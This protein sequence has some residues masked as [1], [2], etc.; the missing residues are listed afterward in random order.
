M[1][2]SALLLILLLITFPATAIAQEQQPPKP[3]AEELEKQKEEWTKNAYRLLDQVIDE[4]QS[5]RL[6]EN[7]VRMQ[8]YAADVLWDRDQGRARS[9]FMVAGDA[10]AELSRTNPE[11]T[12][13]RPGPNQVR[14]PSQLRQELVLT[15][16]RHDAPL[17]YQL[18][19]ATK[20][21]LPVQPVDPRQPRQQQFNADDLLEQSLLAAVAALDPKLAAQNADQMLEKG[22]FPYS[23]S[24]VISEL[25]RQDAEAATKLADKTVKRLQSANLLSNTEAAT[26]ALGLLNPGP[27]IPS[28]ADAAKPE[29]AKTSSQARGPVLDQSVYVDLLGSLI[30]SALKATPPTQQNQRGANNPRAARPGVARTVQVFRDDGTVITNQPSEAQTELMNARRLLSGL[31]RLLPQVD[32]NLPGRAQSVRQKL[33]EMGIA[34][35]NRG[36][37]AQIANAF[38]GDVTADALIQTAATAPTQIQPRL[39]QQAAFKALEEGNVDRARQIATDHLS[40]QRLRDSVMQRID[41]RE[42]A[43]KAEG[44]RLEQVRQSLSRLQSDN[45]RIDLLLQLANDVAAKNPK[46][47]R[48]LLEEARQITNKRA[49]SYENFEQQLRVAHAFASVD[50]SRSFEI[51]D[52][53]ISH[54]NELLSAAQMLSGF[55]TNVFR[56]GEL[57]LQGGSALTSMVNRFGQEIALLAKTDFERSETLAGRFQFAESR[58]MARL[59]IVQGLL[60]VKPRPGSPVTFRVGDNSTVTFRP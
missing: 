38:R 8:I 6:P 54:L 56:D 1:K 59:A 34:E 2:R 14:R 60:D 32:Q 26:L 29:D 4:S 42:L 33:T 45:E 52:P 13:Q 17:A 46:A 39:Y 15:A 28:A 23:I 11:T 16:A 50:A 37:M 44:I 47:Q 43:T 30:D 19:A 48:Q 57:P 20:P 49:T 27:R 58:I 25:R 18:L 31:Q 10:V 55:E 24:N 40:D 9:M 5:L 41:L 7:R 35:N 3:T 21:P 51:L 12:T 36:P 53:G 22:Q